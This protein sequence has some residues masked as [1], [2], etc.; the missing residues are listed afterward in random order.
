MS[1]T[2]DPSTMGRSPRR[3][4]RAVLLAFALLVS[5]GTLDAPGV[6]TAAEPTPDGS[7]VSVVVPATETDSLVPPSPAHQGGD[8]GI[9]GG[10]LPASSSG[11]G[12]GASTNATV[13]TPAEPAVPTRPAT[14]GEAAAVDKEVYIEGDTVVATATG[15]GP[16]EKVQVVL[17][18]DPSVV[19]AVTADASGAVRA[20][21]VVDDELRPGTHALQLTGWCERVAL[22]DVLIGTAGSLAAAGMQAVPVWLWWMLGVIALLALLLALPRLVRTLR[23]SPSERDGAAA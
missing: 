16:S 13:C 4:A 7:S 11:S 10:S 3:R 20:E 9:G 14:S 12:A 8:S 18:N 6:A 1:A 2:P 23:P 21:I 15:F 22:A 19:H 17:F 5:L